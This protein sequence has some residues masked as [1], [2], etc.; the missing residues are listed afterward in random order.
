MC[1]IFPA[2]ADTLG[3][4]AV[5]HSHKDGKNWA[6][7]ENYWIASDSCFNYYAT[8]ITNKQFTIGTTT[9]Q[10]P[11]ELSDRI[12]VSHMALFYFGLLELYCKHLECPTFDI[13]LSGEGIPPTTFK[14]GILS[15][16]LTTQTIDL[17]SGITCAGSFPPPIKLQ[18]PKSTNHNHTN[19]LA[20]YVGK[21][22]AADYA[23]ML[24]SMVD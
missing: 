9:Y 16:K 22:E 6:T 7:N 15:G 11:F 2:F 18:Q 14:L 20:K 12:S 10:L 4:V 19:L 24:L 5:I 23:N 1:S 21:N 13:L 3:T 17:G 8:A